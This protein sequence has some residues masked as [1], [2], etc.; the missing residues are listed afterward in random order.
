MALG[1]NINFQEEDDLE[2]QKKNLVHEN[3]ETDSTTVVKNESKCKLPSI[4]TVA[5]VVAALGVGFAC[6][7]FMPL[8]NGQG[9]AI[10]RDATG[11]KHLLN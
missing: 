7:H 4:K 3:F 6:R 2:A 1:A 11:I 5:G 8:S 10:F 9:M